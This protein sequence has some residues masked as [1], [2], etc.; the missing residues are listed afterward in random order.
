MRSTRV[1]RHV[2]APR[3]AVYRLL[4]DPA[5]IARWKVPEGMTAH[6]H[7]F[8]PRDVKAVVSE[9]VVACREHDVLE[10][11]IVHGKGRGVLRR[12]VHAELR[13]NPAVASFRLAGP[14]AG[15]WGAT[16]VTLRPREP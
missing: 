16:L 9:Y 15:G 7:T 6:V 13:H 8:E 1:H 2:H 3:A 5:A 10:L 4:L 11:R 12:I 14:E